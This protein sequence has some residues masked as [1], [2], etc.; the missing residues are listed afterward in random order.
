MGEDPICKGEALSHM[1][2][3]RYLVFE[4]WSHYV[5][6]EWYVLVDHNEQKVNADERPPESLVNTRIQTCTRWGVKAV[7][8]A[9][10]SCNITRRRDKPWA[11]ILYHYRS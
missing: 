6:C 10:R 4:L 9:W 1:L 11:F 5:I 2:S 3:F 8:C 7:A